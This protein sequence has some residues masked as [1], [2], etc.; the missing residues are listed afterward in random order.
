MPTL[1]VTTRDGVDHTLEADSGQSVMEILRD[2]GISE[3]LAICGGCLSCATC[4]VHVD[5]EYFSQLSPMGEDENDL[6]DGSSDRAP[7]SRLSCQIPFDDSLNGLRIKVA[8][9]D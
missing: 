4:H 8:Q 1:I 5:P 6:L 9:E 3:V 2:G 7:T